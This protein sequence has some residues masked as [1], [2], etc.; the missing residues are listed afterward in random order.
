MTVTISFYQVALF[1]LLI[2]MI[3]AG[4]YLIIALRNFNRLMGNLNIIAEANRQDIIKALALMPTIAEN[5]NDASIGARNS[6]VQAE[7]AIDV[8]GANMAKTAVSVSQTA[9]QVTNYSIVVAEV[10]KALVHAFSN[11]RKSSAC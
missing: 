10:A 2:V 5:V 7:A 4:A 9:D 6:L 3:A 1:L 11:H 8:I